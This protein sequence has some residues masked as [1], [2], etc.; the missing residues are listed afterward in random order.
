ML[1]N[2]ILNL[3]Q[4]HPAHYYSSKW[5]SLSKPIGLADLLVTTV[6]FANHND[7]LLVGGNTS[8][9]RAEGIDFDIGRHV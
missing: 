3:F 5:F 7:V 9:C 1:L 6:A 4:N 2:T 8:C